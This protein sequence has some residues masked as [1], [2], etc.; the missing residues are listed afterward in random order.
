MA[1]VE[2]T[3]LIEAAAEFDEQLAAY[4]RLGELFLAAPLASVKQL[5]RA[6][7]LL[8][9]IAGCEERLQSAGQKLVRALAE[10]RSRQETLAQEVVAHVPTLQERNQRLQELMGE[11]T[12]VAGEVA[13]INTQLQARGEGDEADLHPTVADAHAISTTVLALSERAQ[14]L[15]KTANEA[16]FEELAAQAHALHQRLQSI[17]KKLA[18]AAGN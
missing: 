1:K 12:A 8:A 2:V 6:N 4:A 9:E 17:G 3:P 18:K 16:E 5:E 10:A 14:Q 13:T 15:A 11:L 7:T